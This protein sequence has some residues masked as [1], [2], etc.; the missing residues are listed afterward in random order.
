MK[1]C[2]NTQATVVLV[3]YN[4]MKKILAPSIGGSTEIMQHNVSWNPRGFIQ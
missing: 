3:L 2:S 4:E 1:T